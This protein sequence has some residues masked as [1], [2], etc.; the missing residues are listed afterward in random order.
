MGGLFD[1]F[2]GYRVVT[3]VENRGALTSALVAVDANVLLNLYRYN[4][5]TTSD[6]LAIFEKL[7]DRLVVPFQA[8]HEFHR[9]RLKTIGNPEQ[10]TNDVRVAL[11]KSHQGAVR[12]LDGWSK[13]VALADPEL[14]KM[15]ESLEQVYVELRQII[16]RAAPDLIHPTTPTDKDPVLRRLADLLDGKVLPRPDDERWATMIAEGNRRVGE[17]VPPGYLD[18]D[19]GDLHV[20]RA[21]GDYLIYIQACEEARS[22][23]LSLLIVTNDEKE[24]WWWRRGADLIGPRQEM[25]KE[26]FDLTGERLFLMRPSDLLNYS[27][28]LDVQVSQGSKDDAKTSRTDIDADVDADIDE[29]GEWTTE[30][31]D[32]LLER[33]RAE[34]RRDLADVIL[35]AARQGG[36]ID[37]DAVYV[38]GDYSDDRMLRGFTRPT[39]R[40]TADL[41]AEKLIP[42]S[43][44][45]MLTPLYRG[46][47]RLYAV[48]IPAE[49]T[50][51]LGSRVSRAFSDVSS[52]DADPQS[53]AE[54]EA[55]G[56][57]GPLSD[58]LAAL[59]NDSVR[60]SFGEIEDI[61]GDAL[62]PSARKHLPYWYSTQNSL[63]KAIN[64]A[65]FRPRG[66]R[67]G[68]ETVEFY[69]PT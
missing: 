42:A 6:L 50:V 30:G 26:F 11:D 36:T 63:G 7:G 15:Y 68:I 23:Q 69:R 31:V 39:A 60:M 47:G 8:A 19:K 2:E 12:A 9:N 56:K 22:R 38:L 51:I 62:A 25:A 43:V 64:A 52:R 5:R 65:G 61:I 29:G 27:D 59:D 55:A 24:D 13:K 53:D 28:A 35:E 20:E 49:V 16:D 58:Y 48:R 17:L 21:A 18:A 44:A 67:I 40:I 37:R 34:G 3:D 57:Y 33:L 32:R 4:S 1:G 66:V 10:A 14:K 54:I 45:P 41:Q 46:P